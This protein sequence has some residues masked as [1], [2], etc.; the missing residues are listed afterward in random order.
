MRKLARTTMDTWKRKHLREVQGGCCPLCGDP[1]DLSVKGEG[2][3]DHNHDTGEIRGVLHRSCN[4]AEGKV[5]NAIGRWG[6]KD[7]SY[8][9][10]IAFA[11]RLVKYWMLPGTGLL[12]YSHKSPAEKALATKLKAR[13]RAAESR[14]RKIVREGT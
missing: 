12:Y 7:T 14:A 8:S 4:A 5:A 1:I 9:A 3:I 2:V 13:K 10:I 6:S 11:M